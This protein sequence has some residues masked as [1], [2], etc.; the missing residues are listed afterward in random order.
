MSIKIR[1]ATIEDAG[2]LLEWRNDLETRK[3]S[4]NTDEVTKTEHIAWLSG[5]LANPNRELFVA[6]ENGVPVGTVRA[7]MDD[8]GA[9]LSWTVAPNAR[10]TGT[11]KRMVAIVA[12][13]I[14][15][16]IRA[17]VKVDNS[18][19]IRIAEHAGM[20]F[21]KEIDGV[22]HYSREGFNEEKK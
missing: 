15:G 20:F 21:D 13:Q 17:E 22:L 1:T 4:H 19:S 7:D 18:G 8:N 2:F 10:G 12:N 3:A 5:I 9:E 11:G 6:E 14:S 16:P